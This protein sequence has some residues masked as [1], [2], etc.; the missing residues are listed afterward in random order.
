MQASIA[1]DDFRRD[2]PLIATIPPIVGCTK[3]T[4]NAVGETVVSTQQ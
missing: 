2:T 1:C 3:T 4:S